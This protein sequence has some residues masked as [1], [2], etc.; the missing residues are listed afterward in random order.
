MV[1]LVG[2]VASTV[3]CDQATK[4]IARAHLTGQTPLSFLGG[5]VRIALAQNEGGFLSLGASLPEEFRSAVFLVGVA[6]VLALAAIYL[7]RT[8]ELS[9]ATRACAWLV[10]AGGLS[11][12]LDR[13]FFD[14]RVTDFM[15]LGVGPIRTG[16]FNVADVAI[17]AG[18]IFLV[19]SSWRRN[20]TYPEPPAAPT[21]A[22]EPARDADG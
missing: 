2:V 8:A 12:L 20:P 15:V 22:D 10:W 7:A 16:V 18:G 19:A 1:I 9:F 4:H 11:N 17:M 5:S 3:G 13:I 14:G 6:G 21:P